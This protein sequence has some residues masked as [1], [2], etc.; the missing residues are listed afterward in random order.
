LKR[1]GFS[2]NRPQTSIE[3]GIAKAAEWKLGALEIN[4]NRPEYFPE[5]YD[6]EKRTRLKK[7]AEKAGIELLL[8]AP[9]DINLLS[10]HK[11]IRLAGVERL[12]EMLEFGREINATYFTLHT[13]KVGLVASGS[14]RMKILHNPPFKSLAENFRDSALRLLEFSEGKME[15]GFENTNHFEGFFEE[16]IAGLLEKTNLKL[17]WD[18]GHSFAETPQ[19]MENTLTFFFSRI[20]KVKSLHLHDRKDGKDHLAVGAGTIP[21]ARF[22]EVLQAEPIYKIVE[23]KE[24]SGIETSLNHLMNLKFEQT[25]PASPLSKK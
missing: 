15:L 6:R 23:V 9:D 12:K 14:G 1:L 19:K 7:T 4:L 13:G 18:I 5:Q 25:F 11:N 24:V 3:E 16:V 8:H 22:G 2:L 10:R 20:G 21:W 17:T